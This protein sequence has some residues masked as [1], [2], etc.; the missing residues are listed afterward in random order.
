MMKKIGSVILNAAVAVTVAFVFASAVACG[1]P[2]PT[3]GNTGARAALSGIEV[4]SLPTKSV[5]TVGDDFITDGATITVKYDDGTGADKAVTAD[6]VSG[7][8]K[9]TA[10][11]QYIT[12][13]Y[14]EN[15]TVRK[16]VFS[17]TVIERAPGY[18]RPDPDDR[19]SDEDHIYS[20]GDEYSW[21]ITENNGVVSFESTSTTQYLMFNKLR[22]SGGSVSFKLKVDNND[23]TYSVADGIIFGADTLNAD[24]DNGKFYVC[25]RDRWNELLVFSKDNGAFA[26]QDSTKITGVMRELGVTYSLKFIWDS[27]KDIVYYFMNGNYVGRQQ[28][29]KGF[30]GSYI[31]IYAD[32]PGVTISDI[33]IDE[34]ETYA[35]SAA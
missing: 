3:K 1:A 23:M 11:V 5:Y 17:V 22:F 18:T 15:G 2:A 14:A 6:M 33:V 24:H 7:Y 35:P 9:T 29:N 28:L 31:G 27:G 4:K 13:T 10:G 26:W 8:D 25:G 19:P 12:V 32:H 34:T 16:A 30:K 21:N 20:F